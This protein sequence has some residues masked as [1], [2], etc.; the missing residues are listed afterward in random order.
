[1][2]FSCMHLLRMGQDVTFNLDKSEARDML[3]VRRDGAD[4]ARADHAVGQHE[5]EDG[6]DAGQADDIRPRRQPDGD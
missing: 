3:R 1:V 6:R 4:D 2:T 5:R